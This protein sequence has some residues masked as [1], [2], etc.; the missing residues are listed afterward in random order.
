M[1]LNVCG[2][3]SLQ[4]QCGVTERSWASVCENCGKSVAGKQFRAMQAIIRNSMIH[5]WKECLFYFPVCV[6]LHCAK[7][8]VKSFSFGECLTLDFSHGEITHH[9]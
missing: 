1:L 2:Y 3:F 6:R 4:Q 9:F 5:A 8:A 7:D